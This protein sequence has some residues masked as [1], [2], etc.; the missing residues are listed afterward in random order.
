MSKS[1]I[2]VWVNPPPPFKYFPRSILETT[3]NT[4]MNFALNTVETSF[5]EALGKDYEKWSQ[6]ANY[7]FER[8]N[9]KEFSMTS[10][11]K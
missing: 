5:L 11:D 2:K 9:V 10:S 3:G 4:V 1:D 7:R 6:D 8:A